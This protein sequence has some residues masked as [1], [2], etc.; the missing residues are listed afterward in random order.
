[1][2]LL[3]LSFGAASA[4]ATITISPWVPIFKGVEFATGEA[5]TN[6][7]RL[8]KVR[9]VRV[10]LT[11]PAVEFVST[12]DNGTNA[13]E[14]FGQTTT[15]F[16]NT[17]KPAVGMNANFFSPVSTIPNDP[18]ELSSLAISSNVIVSPFESGR[19]AVLITRS[20]QVSFITAALANYS[21]VWTA[22]SGSDRVLINGVAQLASC[23]TSFCLENPRSAVGLSSNGRYFYLMV[24]DGRQS[25]WSMGATLYETGQWLARFGAWNGLN[26]DGGGSTAMAKLESG[27]AVLL[28]KPSGGVQRVNGNHLGVFAP[29]LAPVILN[30]PLT[31]AGAIG[32]GVTL[33]VNAGGTTPLRYQWRFNGANLAG[34]TK[35]NL[36][37]SNLQLANRGNYS[38]F[39]TNATGTLLSSNAYLDVTVLLSNLV[40]H[41]RP[42][43]ALLTWR[44]AP[45]ATS[46]VEYGLAP[47][48]GTLTPL[49][50]SARTNH[51]VLLVGL[52]PRT[53][54]LFQIRS[55]VGVNEFIAG[56]FAFSTDVS[57]IVDNPQAAYAGAWTVATSSPD[58]FRT[59]YHYASTTAN[60]LPSAQAT[61]T[62]NLP[63]PGQYDVAIWYPQGS[64]R[65]TNAPVTV[66]G[67]SAIDTNYVN[68][69]A[70]GGGW[71]LL[72]TALDC[73][74][75]NGSFAHVGNNSGEPGKVVLADAVRWSY[76]AEQ[77]HPADDT[78]PAWW[79]GYYFGGGAN[80][81]LDVDGDG[82]STR[83]EYVLGT[84]PTNAAARFTFGM[85]P[86]AGGLQFDFSPWQG[87]RSYELQS[88]TD[89]A[90]ES[91]SVLTNLPAVANG[92]GTFMLPVDATEG[93]VFYRLNIRLTE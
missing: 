15:T 13:M 24:I 40:V 12:P 44:S 74:A 60:A 39:I 37:L 31:Q 58:K 45:A 54:Y 64:N 52:L 20:N 29:P 59:N 46:Q 42:S 67:S 10:D 65:T 22:V 38:V 50:T 78:V 73:A 83:A 87:G 66:F 4:S 92:R 28:N 55:R 62:P 23:T 79:S 75:G 49:E 11:E 32:Q 14:T 72:M 53:N 1:M 84:D 48:L 68:Q 69:T 17:Y 26:L 19:P 3:A 36:A 57:V 7:V 47:G 16:V 80:A 63:T 91:W 82:Y 30:Q 86:V 93:G 2:C 61:F 9:I 5:D 90:A 51:G 18:R 33:Y 35:T 6:E 21:N 85:Q 27:A 89:L 71:R 43:S 56:P 8:Q 41:P 88:T 25:T 77:D 76:S 81:A 70:G 34:A